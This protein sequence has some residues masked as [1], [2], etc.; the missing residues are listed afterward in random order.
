MGDR[1]WEE[2]F[3]GISA[4]A[5]LG[6]PAAF[7]FWVNVQLFTCS[8]LFVCLL[9][10]FAAV[11]LS[12][13]SS[14]CRP[15]ASESSANWKSPWSNFTAV[16]GIRPRSGPR[17]WCIMRQTDRFRTFAQQRE[18]TAKVQI[19]GGV[20]KDSPT[21]PRNNATRESQPSQTRVKFNNA[22]FGGDFFSSFLCGFAVRGR[23]FRRSSVA[24]CPAHN[25]AVP[26]GSVCVCVCWV[27]GYQPAHSTATATT[28]Q[29]EGDSFNGSIKIH[30]SHHKCGVRRLQSSIRRKHERTHTHTSS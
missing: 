13:P 9:F 29:N 18:R 14:V 24:S 2:G 27:G 8:V 30:F 3:C 1:C 11:S 7:S 17:P 15:A 22:W 6:T 23:L 26:L 16:R 19:P 28:L 12:V 20:P 25:D 5:T 10:F 21:F 4:H